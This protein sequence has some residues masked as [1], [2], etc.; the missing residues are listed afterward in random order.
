MMESTKKTTTI[1]D[2]DWHNFFKKNL[3]DIHFKSKYK[4]M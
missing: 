2:F 1:E 4:M 3:I